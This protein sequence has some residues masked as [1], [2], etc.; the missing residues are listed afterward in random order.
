[1]TFSTELKVPGDP[2]FASLVESV[3]ADGAVR[4]GLT[5]EQRSNVVDA[6]VLG[7]TAIVAE[8]LTEARGPIRIAITSVPE[9]FEVSLFEHG[10]PVDDAYARRDPKWSELIAR[11]DDAHWHSHGVAGSELRLIV[12][13]AHDGVHDASAAVADESDVPLAPEQ[14]YAIRG[15]A[16]SDAPGIAR[17]FYLTYGYDYDVNAVYEPSRL[18]ELNAAGRYT[19]IVAVTRDDEVV[20]H[21]ALVRQDEEP[22]AEGGGAIV[23]PAHRGRDLLNR[24]RREAENQA[25]RLGLA[26]Y[27]TEPVTDHGRTQHASES[28][29]AKACGISLGELRR[30]FLAKHLELSTT[31]QRQ[32]CMLYVRPLRERERRAI[33]VPPQ[34]RGIVEQ[35]Y[36][37]LDLPV[38]IDGGS[39]PKGHNVMR[40]GIVKA[41]GIGTIDVEQVGPNTAVRVI[42]AVK[43][44]LAIRRLGALYASLPLEDPGMPS[45]C[46]AL[47]S[48]GFFFAG[49]GPWMLGGK[50]ALRMQMLL[51]PIDLTGLVVVG[52][53]G[54]VLLDYIGRERERVQGASADG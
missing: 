12:Q 37:Q 46:D 33:Y 5:D 34:H 38:A 47:E 51:E 32:S 52:D 23:L 39:T 9:H 29:G 26:G 18:I 54:K 15:F 35:I 41:D 10:L 19:S 22:I 53:F 13:R 48:S 2:A 11:V 49:V 14:P 43:D 21:Y 4:S 6:A 3:V 40:T 50:D 30:K 16:P 27:F 31:T 45:L 42:Q 28:F 1:V 8:A 25:V 36:R 20:G 7:F 44:L 24:L 17:A